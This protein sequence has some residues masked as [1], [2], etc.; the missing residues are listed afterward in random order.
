MDNRWHI[1]AAAAASLLMLSGPCPSSAASETPIYAFKGKK[2][3]SAPQWPLL[4]MPNSMS[5]GS[6]PTGGQYQMGEVFRMVPPSAT[7]SSWRKQ[8]VYDFA[9]P[10]TLGW[11]DGYAPDGNLVPGPEGSGSFYGTTQYG[12]EST[13]AACNAVEEATKGCGTI[14]QVWP[15]AAAG[16]TWSK[17]I[18][19]SFNNSGDGTGPNS[20]IEDSDGNL[21]GTTKTTVFELSPSIV[22]GETVWTLTVLHA[23]NGTTDGTG[24]N[25]G[26][27][28]DS[29]GVIYGTTPNGALTY[30]N[31]NNGTVFTL[32]RSSSPGAWTYAQVYDFQG[33]TTDGAVPNGGLLGGEGTGS[34]PGVYLW[35]T[36]Q[37]GGAYGLGTLFQLQQEY[38]DQPYYDSL[39]HSFSGGSD[40]GVPMAGLFESDDSSYWGTASQGGLVEAAYACESGCGVV[41]EYQRKSDF[42]HFVYVFSTIAEFAGY[43]YGDG[44]DPNTTLGIDNNGSLYGMTNSGGTTGEG[45]IFM[46]ADAA[47]VYTVATPSITPPAGGYTTP[48][49]ITITDSTGGATIHYTTD[50][51][52][53]TASSAAYVEPITVSSNETIKAMATLNGWLPSAIAHAIYKIEP[54]AAK[55]TF[56]LK[57]GTYSTP[58]PLS[59]TDADTSLG[60]SIY[61]TT[62]GTKPTTSSTLYTGTITVSTTETVEAVAVLNGYLN[63]AIQSENYTITGD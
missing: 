36:T 25:P 19:Y 59:M 1:L 33:G 26:L 13:D 58:Q 62:D 54:K 32:T 49:T 29:T 12:G 43:G 57:S 28:M 55:P 14:F 46:L 44:S 45:T 15:P 35:G 51:T 18:L 10:A 61:Y 56:S 16:D 34:L 30:P 48:Q 5:Y 50:G 2:D 3:G 21:Y 42:T 37:A 39:Q 47:P 6:T 27:L 38:L 4:V 52:I 11:T 60:A 9:N 23:F 31:L 40:G 63:S 7:D 8:T 24:P 41:F 20:L 17:A 22:D 53:P